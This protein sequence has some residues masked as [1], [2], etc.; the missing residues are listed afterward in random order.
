MS[1]NNLRFLL[2]VI[3]TTFIILFISCKREVDIDNPIFNLNSTTTLYPEFNSI[4]QLHN[5]CLKTI[6][7]DRN[8]ITIYNIEKYI[9]SL[10]CANIG[11][12]TDTIHIS[13]ALNYVDNIMNYAD[14]LKK[15]NTITENEYQFYSFLDSVCS[16]PKLTSSELDIAINKFIKESIDTSKLCFKEEYNILGTLFVLL[17]S[18]NYWYINAQNVKISKWINE[19]HF[20]KIYI[21]NVLY[22]NTKYYMMQNII[23]G[24]AIADALAYSDCIN[25]YNNEDP[26]IFNNDYHDGRARAAIAACE[27]GAAKVSFAYIISQL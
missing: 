11:I 26:T 3:S 19:D 9:N 16:I 20:K 12:C 2:L 27:V 18:N 8:F 25:Y 5:F 21:A 14:S 22:N 1:K 4:G 23:T 15:S 10:L 13:I 6:Q 24:T 7:D 17:H